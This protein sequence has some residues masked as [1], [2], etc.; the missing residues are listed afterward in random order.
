MTSATR[1]NLTTNKKWGSQ[2]D[3]FGLPQEITPQNTSL[4]LP[5]LRQINDVNAIKNQK[6]SQENA[7]NLLF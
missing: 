3:S 6:L 7:K 4:I 2:S 5:F 1:L